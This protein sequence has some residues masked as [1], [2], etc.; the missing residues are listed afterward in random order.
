MTPQENRAKFDE[1]KEVVSP[2]IKYLNDNYCPHVTA[3]VT[4]TSVEILEGSM[5]IPN[6]FD[7]VK[8]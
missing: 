3:I 8:D 2:L 6:I 4:P 7:F 1:L 5:A